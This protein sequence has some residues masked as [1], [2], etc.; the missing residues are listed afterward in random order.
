MVGREELSFLFLLQVQAMVQAAQEVLLRI[1]LQRQHHNPQHLR[2]D[3]L[4]LFPVAVH[5]GA[6]SLLPPLFFRP[7]YHV[8]QG[9]CRQAQEIVP[10]LP[11]GVPEREPVHQ[12]TELLFVILFL[13]AAASY[14]A[15]RLT[16]T[17]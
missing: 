13:H 7:W 15:S 6:V 2:E 14:P 9:Q 5:D 16:R 12:G 17:S 1:L 3:F 10:Y 11:S 4:F 8:C